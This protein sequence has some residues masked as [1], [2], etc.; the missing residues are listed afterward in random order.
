MSLQ[1]HLSLYKTIYIKHF[2]IR[3][4]YAIRAKF[5]DSACPLYTAGAS[6]R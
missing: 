3:F 6:L 2:P 1:N 5:Q 4:I